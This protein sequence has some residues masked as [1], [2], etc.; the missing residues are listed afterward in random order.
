M[1]NRM[2]YFATA[3]P[4]LHPV[5]AREIGGLREG[6]ADPLREFDG[7]NDVVSFTA[8]GHDGILGL[9]TG[10]DVFVEV[11]SAHGRERL[12]SVVRDLWDRRGL[13]Q[14]LSAYG[15]SV[16]PLRARMTFRVVARVLSERAFLRTE[17]RDEL[18]R[19][20]LQQRPRWRVA[21]PSELEL[22]A[23]ETSPGRFRLGLRLSS[24][25]MRH[26]AGRT[27]ERP[28]ALRP[29]VAAAMVLLADALP[30]NQVPQ[31]GG[32]VANQIPQAGGRVANP[33][34]QTGGRVASQ[35]PQA[36]GRPAGQGP[37][38]GGRPAGQ[39]LLDPCCGSGTVL[40]EAAAVGW[41]PVGADLDPAAIHATRRNLA[42]IQTTRQDL[43]PIQTTR[44]DLGAIQ[45][46]PRNLGGT[47]RLLGADVRRL[48]LADAS[49]AAVASNL[50]FGKQYELQGHAGPWFTAMFDE[51]VRVTRPGGS[52]VLL[53]PRTPAF[54]RALA[55]RSMIVLVERLD[56]RLLGV[57]TALWSL[58]RR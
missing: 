26:R 57:K 18:V 23:L 10:E 14:A 24:A 3:I 56:L 35:I 32:R 19:R 51:L 42:A 39:V 49:V 8:R 52:V 1:V 27:V 41:E 28:G 4:G 34:P 45:A 6:R 9:R 21:D 29:T 53:V 48:P 20:T 16:R 31:T 17:L 44:Q 37:R 43:G 13:E 46:T 30:T 11:S 2:R 25:A 5:L 55:L 15:A 40:A 50:P 47:A 7:R 33:V 36:G 12:G 58:R 38:T 22:W 54:E